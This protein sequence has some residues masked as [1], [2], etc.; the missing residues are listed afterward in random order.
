MS[1]KITTLIPLIVLI[2]ALVGLAT[3]LVPNLIGYFNYA[4]QAI[5]IPFSIDYGEGP[6]LDQTSH[7]AHFENIYHSTL[8]NPPYTISNYPPLFPL[9]Q[10]P[11]YWIFG[12]AFW[13]GRVL[14]VIFV[15]LTALFIF[16][17]LFTLFHD[18]AGSIV[19]G[20]LL[21]AFPYI[22]HWSLYNRIDELALALSWAALFVTV[23]CLGPARLEG[24]SGWRHEAARVLKSGRFW[25]VVALF[26]GSIYSRQ[27]YA[28]A[29]PA[30]AFFWLLFGSSGS[31]RKRLTQA[32]LLGLAVGGVTLI[33]FVV[34]NLLTAGGFYLNIVVANVNAFSWDT[35]MNYVHQIEDK[36]WPLLALAGGFLVGKLILNLVR[37]DDRPQTASQAAGQPVY[38]AAALVLPYLLAAGAGSITIGKDGS[39]VNY[40][41]EFSAALAL[42]AGA[43]LAWVS[44]WKLWF[45]RLVFQILVIV[46]LAFQANIMVDWSFN[47][48]GRY[49]GEQYQNRD[50]V[51]RV[52]KIIKETPG[53]VI[54]D[55]YM[56]LIPLAGKHLYFQPFEFKQMA[57]AK[58]W[59]EMPFLEEISAHKFDLIV[60]YQ[61]STW[62]AIEARYTP[63]QRNMIELFYR[64]DTIIGDVYIYRPK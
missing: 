4:K 38:N 52:E 8:I 26:V 18:W 29:A 60:W 48:F 36:L 32:V 61:P 39:N 30:A 56:G 47:D 5:A 53:I 14:N 15:L 33:L 37:L 59:D 28:L 6:L 54:A 41:L 46:L 57:Q 16:L 12:A 62:P 7:L 22:Q 13:Y 58:V 21:V 44:S 31:W 42:A 1:K 19:G 20:L 3:Q 2:L 51:A 49:L 50:Q 25:L 63:S 55:E 11:F 45:P 27:T 10:V 24:P 34:L 23:R 64:V 40:L 43:A 17:T 35:V 9:I